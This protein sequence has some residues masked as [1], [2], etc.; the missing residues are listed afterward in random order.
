MLASLRPM[1]CARATLTAGPSHKRYAPGTKVRALIF[2][3]VDSMEEFR[4][5]SLA[6]LAKRGWKR[7]T[8]DGNKKLADDH[9]FRNPD[10]DEAEAFRA[11]QD[12]GLGIVV[13]GVLQ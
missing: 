3:T 12:S 1:L 7:V 11:A 8:I 9:P 2:A 6:P 13:L 4:D 5:E 10:S